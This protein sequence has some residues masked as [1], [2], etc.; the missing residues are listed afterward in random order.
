MWQSFF[1][2]VL[3]VS[4]SQTSFCLPLNQVAAAAA[5]PT[6]RRKNKVVLQD[7]D[8]LNAQRVKLKQDRNESKPEAANTKEKENHACCK[9][10]G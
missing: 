2:A 5:A 6:R 9:C 4:N 3:S 10:D 8:L 7:V 1:Y